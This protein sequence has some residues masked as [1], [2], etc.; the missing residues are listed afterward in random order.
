MYNRPYQITNTKQ[1]A[2]MTRLADY[3]CALP[4]LSSSL[5]TALWESEVFVNEIPNDAEI[6][7]PLACKL[8]HPIIFRECII[9]IVGSMAGDKLAMF[10]NP[11]LDRM[12]AMHYGK[13]NEKI[14]N[15][16]LGILTI[17]LRLF[18]DGF[19]EATRRNAIDRI[20]AIAH[21]QS[22]KT[23]GSPSTPGF[24]HQLHDTEFCHPDIGKEV[25][26][27]VAPLLKNNLKLDR[28]GGQ[29]GKHRFLFT[30]ITDAEVPWNTTE[31]DW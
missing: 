10:N 22:P 19:S 16:C 5:Y 2:T 7:L 1:L 6:I 26:A 3:Y 13:L 11:K 12:I 17:G 30:G 23:V 31:I 9:H 8:R 21:S 28:S 20:H 18:E 25:R 14:S 4:I 15:A 27:I 29:L 24:F